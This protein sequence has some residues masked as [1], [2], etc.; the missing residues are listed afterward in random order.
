MY[1]GFRT[2]IV[3]FLCVVAF[4]IPNINIL[5]TIGGALLGTI[6]N[7]LLPVLFYNRAYAYSAKN[8]MLEGDGPKEGEPSLNEKS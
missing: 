7:I 3:A 5:L 4:S 2:L 1:I 6:V 8:R